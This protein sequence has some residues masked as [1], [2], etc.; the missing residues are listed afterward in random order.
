MRRWLGA[1]VPAIWAPGVTGRSRC[2]QRRFE[3]GC[4]S[5]WIVRDTWLRDDLEAS[6]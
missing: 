3:I 5:R 4:D 1:K 6:N 2:G